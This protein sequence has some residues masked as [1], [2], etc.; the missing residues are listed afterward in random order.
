MSDSCEYANQHPVIEAEIDNLKRRLDALEDAESNRMKIRANDMR[1]F[2][3]E[4]KDTNTKV[5]AL[6]LQMAGLNGKLA[7]AV[8][9]SSGLGALGMFVIAKLFEAGGK[10]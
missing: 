7:A 4:L 10:P 8:F 5:T 3:E 6:M 2:K 9:F 1:E